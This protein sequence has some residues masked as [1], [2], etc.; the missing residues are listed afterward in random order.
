APP[1]FWFFHDMPLR[2]SLAMTGPPTGI[3][4]YPR[5]SGNVP[6]PL[7]ACNRPGRWVNRE[8]AR[9]AGNPS[10]RACESAKKTRAQPREVP[11]LEG[12]GRGY[13]DLTEQDYFRLVLS[14][15]TRTGP[16]A[17]PTFGYRHAAEMQA[18]MS[19]GDEP[20]HMLSAK[21]S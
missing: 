1:V 10:R 14:M 5:C 16:S 8:M 17:W 6:L 2:G 11:R 3:R 15:G 4:P 9:R 21:A 13:S 18:V 12:F 7:P 20:K 19:G